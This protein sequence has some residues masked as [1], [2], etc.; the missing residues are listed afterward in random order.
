[1]K[2]RC[3]KIDDAGLMPLSDAQM[4]R[5]IYLSVLMALLLP[6]F[7]GGSIMGL[8]GFYPLPEFYLI[9][10]SYTGLYVIAVVTTVLTLVPQTVCC[11]FNTR[12]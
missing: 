11:C 4:R 3:L 2:V 5:S 9:F 6:P 8:V 10:F 1:M 12:E 7:L